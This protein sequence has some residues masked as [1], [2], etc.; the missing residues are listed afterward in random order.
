MEVRIE[1]DIEHLGGPG[2]VWVVANVE[3]NSLAFNAAIFKSMAENC[4][5]L[6]GA[7]YAER[8]RVYFEEEI[9]GFGERAGARKPVEEVN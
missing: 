6:L 5:H 9:T 1:V 2:K 8:D 4:N 7:V 3:P